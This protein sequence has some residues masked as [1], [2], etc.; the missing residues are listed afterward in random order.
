VDQKLKSILI[1]SSGP[2]EGKSTTA[3]NL[4]IALAQ[5]GNKVVLIDGDL[6]RPVVHSI[7]G[8]DKE[9]GLTNHFMGTLSYKK[10]ARKT[11]I[12]N[13]SI[14][15]SGVLPPNPSELLASEKMQEL[16]SQLQDDYDIILVDSPPIIAV[17]DAAILSTKVDGTILVVSSGQTNRDAIQRARDLLENVDARILG[18]LLNGVDLQGMY[19]SYYYYYYYHYYYNYYSKPGKKHKRSRRY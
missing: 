1:T 6:R 7:F 18:V 16:L 17:T 12:D 19:G 4:A 8:M 11:I 5:A 3:A 2:K 10:L 13:L 15:T 9:D 14:I